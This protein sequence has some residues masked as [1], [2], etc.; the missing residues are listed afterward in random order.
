MPAIRKVCASMP[1]PT[2]DTPSHRVTDVSRI[3]GAARSYLFRLMA[4]MAW[5][6]VKPRLARRR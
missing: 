4:V 5:S 3:A 1:A 2:P 6:W